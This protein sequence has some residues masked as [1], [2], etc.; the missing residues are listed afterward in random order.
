MVA[1]QDAQRLEWLSLKLQEM[2]NARQRLL[3]QVAELEAAS[4]TVQAEYNTIFNRSAAIAVLPNELLA[5]IFEEAHSSEDGM[6]LLVSQ[7]TCRWRDVAI[8]TPKLWSR[9]CL[10]SKHAYKEATFGILYLTRSK[11]VA[12][13][14]T[15]DIGDTNLHVIPF[16]HMVT[17]HIHRCRRL[18]INF[19]SNDDH[20][21]LQHPSNTFLNHLVPLSAPLLE[22]LEVSYEDC[23]IRGH[24]TDIFM[25]G[26]PVLAI[27]RVA[28]AAYCLPPLN[29]VTTLHLINVGPCING[30]KW[31]NMLGALRQLTLLEVDGD[32]VTDWIPGAAVELPMLRILQVA[33]EFQAIYETI[34]A[35]SL[36]SLTLYT[37]HDPELLFLDT[38]W[39][40]GATKFPAIHT[41]LLLYCEGVD[42]L[43]PLMRTFPR[44]QTAVFAFKNGRRSHKVLQMLQTTD[45]EG[46]Y[47]PRLHTL[48]LPTLRSFGEHDTRELVWDCMTSRISMGQPI[49][50]L[51]LGKEALAELI[52]VDDGLPYPM[53]WMDL[54]DVVEYTEEIKA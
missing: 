8:N 3:A 26:A 18:S 51:S 6:E 21:H 43:A 22:S 50:A 20:G 1:L 37:V 12:L 46:V 14:L 44:I 48:A 5:S 54:V 2:N 28:S 36:T 10:N 32:T 27:V 42:S 25:G 47:W 19:K 29:S 39:S 49:G 9:I 35:P 17:D 34:D 24:L 38:L 40:L 31:R 30:E 4:Y 45:T 15:V 41:I 33:T 16:G 13:D 23:N 53:S 52:P 11:V 7:V